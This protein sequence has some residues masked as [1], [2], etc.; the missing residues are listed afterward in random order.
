LAIVEIVGV[1]STS[2]GGSDDRNEWE[3]GDTDELR[4]HGNGLERL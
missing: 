1:G 4:F 2:A 3:C